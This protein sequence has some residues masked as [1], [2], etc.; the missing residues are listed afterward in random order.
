MAKRQQHNRLDKP[1]AI[2]EMHIGSWRRVLG[3]R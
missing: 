2:Y 3:A 1:M